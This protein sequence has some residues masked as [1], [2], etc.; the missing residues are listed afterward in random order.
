MRRDNSRAWLRALLSP[1]AA[2]ALVLSF[3]SQA[4]AVETDGADFNIIVDAP[5]DMCM[6]QTDF[7]ATMTV[8][9]N[10][11]VSEP[12]F[13]PG[14][15]P[16]LYITADWADGIGCDPD[17]G[18]STSIE[19]TGNVVVLWSAT[20]LEI[21]SSE[22]AGPSGCSVAQNGGFT[23]DYDAFMLVPAGTVAGTYAGTVTLTWTP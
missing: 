5:M 21:T 15:T 19:L 4:T 11:W 1:I 10:V 17:T 2:L 22:C 13:L 12:S 9:D 3:S 16:E 23:V 18:A 6:G 14:G 7:P 8:Y 20:D